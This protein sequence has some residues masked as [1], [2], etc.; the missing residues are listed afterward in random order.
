MELLA[1]VLIGGI[2]AAFLLPSLV[3]G[4]RMAPISSTRSFHRSQDLL[5]S[6]ATSDAREV[7]LRKR[8]AL[9]RQRILAALAIGALLALLIAIVQSSVTWLLLAIAFDLAVAGYVATLIHLRQ[10]ATPRAHVVP[11]QVVEAEDPHRAS[12]RVVAG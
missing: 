10:A 1:F 8:T 5:A 3:D 9:R 12:V 2:W 4:R 11:L 6:V 7:M